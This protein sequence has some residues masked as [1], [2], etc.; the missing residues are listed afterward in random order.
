M[1]GPQA[2][3][4]SDHAVSGMA[5]ATHD[6][7]RRALELDPAE[8]AKLAE[9]ILGRVD[10]DASDLADLDAAF[11]AELRRR[12]ERALSDAEGPGIPADVERRLAERRARGEPR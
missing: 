11:V 12:A 1:V 9:G 6:L 5:E 3:G 2:W 4:A 10:D 7:L 8:R